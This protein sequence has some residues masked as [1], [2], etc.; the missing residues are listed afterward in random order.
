MD[1]RVFN[2]FAPSNVNSVSAAYRRHENT[3]RRAYGQRIQ[4]IELASFTPIVMSAVGG[5]APEAITFY[6]RLASLL[7]LK[8]D[9]EY[10]VVMGWLHCSLSFLLLRSAIACVHGAHSSIGQFHKA[11]PPLDLVRVE[12]NMITEI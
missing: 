5:L 6:K 2:P 7:V 4:E 9:D 11:T 1:V 8:W 12:S 10:S 3:K